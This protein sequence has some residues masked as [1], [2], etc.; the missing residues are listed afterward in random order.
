ML[1]PYGWMIPSEPNMSRNRGIKIYIALQNASNTKTNIENI[2]TFQ[3]GI[4][5]PKQWKITMSAKGSTRNTI[6]TKPTDFVDTLSSG[7]LDFLLKKLEVLHF[8]FEVTDYLLLITN[9]PFSQIAW[10][11][12]FRRL[13][14]WDWFGIEYRGC[15]VHWNIGLGWQCRQ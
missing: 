9:F 8:V 14:F 11:N 4:L 6:P 12:T 1:K 7:T 13:L 15:G 2:K 10:T 5:F 3:F